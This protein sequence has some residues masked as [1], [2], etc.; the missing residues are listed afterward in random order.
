[1]TLS[2]LFLSFIP[3]SLLQCIQKQPCL[4]TISSV[5][6]PASASDTLSHN[7]ASSHFNYT[8]A[9]THST[10]HYFKVSTTM[11][12]LPRLV[13]TVCS[14][15][16][17]LVQ[18]DC[19]TV[20]LI[21]TAKQLGGWFIPYWARSTCGPSWAQP[22]CAPSVD[23]RLWFGFCP[24]CTKEFS[25][26]GPLTEATVLRYWA[27]K[28]SQGMRR[29][30]IPAV[31][32]LGALFGRSA[33]VHDDSHVVRL[34]M[35]TLSDALHIWDAPEVFKSSRAY[36]YGSGRRNLFEYLEDIRW[37]TLDKARR[38]PTPTSEVTTALASL[39]APPRSL[40]ASAPSNSPGGTAAPVE[41]E[42]AEM[43][44]TI[45][46][47]THLQY[48]SYSHMEMPE[49]R[50]MTLRARANRSNLRVH[51]SNEDD[52]EEV[53]LGMRPQSPT[54]EERTIDTPRR[55]E[56]LHPGQA[57]MDEQD[58]DYRSPSVQQFFRNV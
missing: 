47:T 27:Y 36:G 46:T 34:E 23:I 37:A 29:P 45:D 10:Y 28:N 55:G 3:D 33:G 17:I 8:K 32:P 22:I 43:R 24:A 48:Q 53:D 51:F 9:Y 40:S 30:I 12:L 35:V 2:L 49:I 50:S 1:M 13:Y 56:S 41:I 44:G 18:E 15:E 16:Y 52:F 57:N 31:V 25:I 4:L 39:L 21:K 26:H 6:R 20:Q 5:L 14:H 38:S 58:Y 54:G 7:F 11:C 42:M 19:A